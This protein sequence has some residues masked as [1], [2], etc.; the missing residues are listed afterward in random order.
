[1]KLSFFKAAAVAGLASVVAFSPLTHAGGHSKQIDSIHFLIDVFTTG[2]TLNAC[3]SV[4]RDAGAQRV[5]V[6][7]IGHG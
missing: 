5:K 7:T 1:M 2:S 3:A 4:L 6:A